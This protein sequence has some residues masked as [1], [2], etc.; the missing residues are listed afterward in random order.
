MDSTANAMA[1]LL[2]GS[3]SDQQ[4]SSCAE[5]LWFEIFKRCDNA[6]L[7]LAELTCQLFHRILRTP[8]FW[9]EK[10]KYDGVALPS[11][12]WRKYVHKEADNTLYNPY[13]TETLSKAYAFD[14]KRICIGQPFNRNLAITINSSC[15]LKYL[16]QKG[17]KFRSGGDGI[18]LE[19]PPQGIDPDEI[20]VCFATSYEW[21]SRYFEI[22]LDKA[23]VQDWVMDLVRP[24]ITICERCICRRDCGAVYMLEAKL[25]KLD[26]K[27][28]D[29]PEDSD[30][31]ED[32][33]A[34]DSD[35]VEARKQKNDP[36]R[37]R[38][39]QRRWEELEGGK[40]WELMEFVFKDYPIGMRKLGVLSQGKDTHYWAGHY[41]CKFG[42]TEVHIKLPNTPG[43]I[44]LQEDS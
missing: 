9:I 11:V 5:V 27:L 32:S 34:D 36:T 26:E 28:D 44:N 12:S 42:A 37:Y 23:G 38:C 24:E 20:S 10:C 8:K 13:D 7:L 17:M 22:E 2:I 16:K 6:T 39:A 40:S 15:T 1:G 18:I 41:G 14:Y 30:D 35:A 4:N 31:S 3:E 21:C 33:A 25:L 43:L 19:H 29:R